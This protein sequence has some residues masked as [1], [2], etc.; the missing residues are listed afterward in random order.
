MFHR[1]GKT[2][3]QR[4]RLSHDSL[5][6]NPVFCLGLIWVVLTKHSCAAQWKQIF[7]DFIEISAYLRNVRLVFY[8]D[9]ILC[10]DVII[11]GFF[12]WWVFFFSF[13]PKCLIHLLLEALRTA[14]DS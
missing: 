1:T 11:A 12:Y 8:F 3:F 13:S 6:E 10:H 5:E 2:M 9:H 7:I 4:A 14:F